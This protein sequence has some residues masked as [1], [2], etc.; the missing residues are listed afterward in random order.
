MTVWELE[1]TVSK[2]LLAWSAAS[3]LVGLGLL[4]SGR[5][6]WTAFGTQ[7]LAWS[8]VDALIALLGFWAMKRRRARLLDPLAPSHLVQEES[9]LRRLLWINTGL[10]VLYVVTGLAL[11]LTLGRTDLRWL[12]HGWGIV[13]QGAFLFAF[14]LVHAQ[15]VPTTLPSAQ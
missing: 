8:A 3:M 7:A 4:F 12:G 13:V 10:D 6:V 11:A 15:S 9:M 14:D 1:Q 2:R 5:R